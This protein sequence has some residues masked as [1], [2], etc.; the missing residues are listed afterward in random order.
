MPIE[1]LITLELGPQGEEFE[2]LVDTGPDRTCVTKL[3][4][5][6][7]LNKTKSCKVKGAKGEL[8]E[9]AIIDNVIVGNSREGCCDVLFLPKLGCNLLG[10]DL[11]IQLGIRVVPQDG[12][13]VARV[14]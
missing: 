14:M 12:R 8:F 1:P 2:F 6:Y 4:I 10:R 13:M 7:K 11:Q 9:T 5:G 3:P